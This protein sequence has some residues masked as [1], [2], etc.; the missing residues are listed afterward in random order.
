MKVKGFCVSEGYD[1]INHFLQKSIQIL[2][3]RLVSGYFF[4]EYQDVETRRSETKVDFVKTGLGKTVPDRLND[5]FCIAG[6]T[7]FHWDVQI[8]VE[9][10]VS[11]FVIL[12]DQP[13]PDQE[14][15]SQ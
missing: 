13:K 1:A 7:N 8:D 5:K 11:T 12:W 2:G 14:C 3:V 4:I 10:R 15:E 6:A 9:Q